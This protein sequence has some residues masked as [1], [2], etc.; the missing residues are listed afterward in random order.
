M[1]IPLGEIQ[2][3]ADHKI[4]WNFKA[5][6]IRFDIFHAARRFVQENAGFD[7]ARL[8]RLQFA[9]HA[10]HRFAGIQNIVHQQHVAS[11]HV[12]PQFFGEKQIAGFHAETIAGNADKIQAQ[13]QIE[14]P[15]QIREEHDRAVEK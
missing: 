15:D 10:S 4:I 2:S 7:P 1:P 9:E 11:A 13:R 3:I 12:E 6:I 8:E 14:A 5:D